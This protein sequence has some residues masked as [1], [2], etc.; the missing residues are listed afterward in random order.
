[1]GNELTQRGDD[2]HNVDEP[3][4]QIDAVGVPVDVLGAA[5]EKIG[6]LPHAL[7]DDPVVEDQDGCDD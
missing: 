5:L 1:V 6:D 3:C 2:G 4:A 7:A